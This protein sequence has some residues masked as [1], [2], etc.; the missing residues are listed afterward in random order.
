MAAIPYWYERCKSCGHVYAECVDCG[1][2]VCAC[3]SDPE[4]HECDLDEDD[5]DE[6]NDDELD[7]E[8]E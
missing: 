8:D 1:T 7:E 3:D 6:D 2:K 4:D 5:W